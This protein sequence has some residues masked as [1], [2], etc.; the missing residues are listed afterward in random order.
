MQCL[1]LSSLIHRFLWPLI[2]Y[3]KFLAKCI[4]KLKRNQVDVKTSLSPVS[5]FLRQEVCAVSDH[6]ASLSK[7]GSDTWM[8]NLPLFQGWTNA[9]TNPE[10]EQMLRDIIKM[11]PL[12]KLSESKEDV[13]SQYFRNII[14]ASFSKTMHKNMEQLHS[15][16]DDYQHGEKKYVPGPGANQRRLVGVGR[17][18]GSHRPPRGNKPP[19]RKQNGGRRRQYGNQYQSNMV[20]P[21]NMSMNQSMYQYPP[22]YNNSMYMPPHAEH[23]YYYGQNNW[24][25]NPQMDNMNFSYLDQSMVSTGYYPVAGHGL[26]VSVDVASQHGE[27]MSHCSEQQSQV[28][29]PSG[30]NFSFI[31]SD[32]CKTPSKGRNYQPQSPHWSHLNVASCLASPGG[33]HPSSPQ[34][35]FADNIH[36]NVPVYGNGNYN[37][38]NNVSHAVPPS[39]ATMFQRSGQPYFP[40]GNQYSAQ[41]SIPSEVKAS[42]ASSSALT[43]DSS[44]NNS[45][46]GSKEGGADDATAAAKI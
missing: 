40:Q 15:V 2:H 38:Y 10:H 36:G 11:L 4:K 32:N 29:P 22:Q 41:P 23:E 37:N 34:H 7:F 5:A 28:G 42:D 19:S 39:P 30:M 16:G 45:S 44:S 17:G 27:E 3:H 20:N 1:V 18:S 35:F 14:S 8:D 46:P 43:V 31:G 13:E 21:M 6:L 26:D 33:V 24:V 12:K 9:D 25:P